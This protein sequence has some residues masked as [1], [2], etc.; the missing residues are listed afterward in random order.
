MP[1]MPIKTWSKETV[2]QRFRRARGLGGGGGGGGAR[3]GGGPIIIG[4]TFGEVLG[5][6]RPTVSEPRPAPKIG[7]KIV[8]SPR[9]S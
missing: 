9:W 4:E 7:C 1:N 3:G 2:A 6:R 8:I 5:P